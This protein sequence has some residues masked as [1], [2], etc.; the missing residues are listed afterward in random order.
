MGRG[1]KVTSIDAVDEFAAALRCFQHDAAEALESL[2]Q[3]VQR[4]AQWIE[5]DQKQYWTG[6]LRRSERQVQEARIN[7]QR[8]MTYKRVG[9]HRPACIEEKRALERAQRRERLCREKLE[10][11][12]KWSRAIGRAV[13]EFRSGVGQLSQW[14][15]ADAERAVGLLGRIRHTLEQ[16]VAAGSTADLDGALARLPW[17][18][19]PEQEPAADGTAEGE[20]AAGGEASGQDAATDDFE[21]WEGGHHDRGEQEAG[22]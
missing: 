12:R 1:A 9:A 22:P 19:P 17:T 8:A 4:V 21:S 3:G 6:Q 5:H 7:L 2:Q 13:F 16:Y 10:A 11:V 15:E 18:A 14:L 20:S